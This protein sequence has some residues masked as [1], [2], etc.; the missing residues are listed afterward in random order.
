[1]ADDLKWYFLAALIVLGLGGL[2]LAAVFWP[3]PG[4]PQRLGWVRW[5]GLGLVLLAL[6][7]G[8]AWVNTYVRWMVWPLWDAAPEA[9]VIE[10][11]GATR[12]RVWGDGRIIWGDKESG[13]HEGRLSAAQMLDLLRQGD[14]VDVLP[15]GFQ[16]DGVY[17]QITVHF[18]T[19][20]RK[21]QA[22]TASNW[23]IKNQCSVYAERL[24][25]AA[26]ASA[27]TAP[28]T[29]ATRFVQ[30][31]IVAPTDTCWRT[32]TWDSAAMGYALASIS[33]R[34]R[35]ITP[36]ET[37]A[38]AALMA[39]SILGHCLQEGP[40]RYYLEVFPPLEFP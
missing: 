31:H 18:L 28:Y 8:N 39:S 12:V 33:W 6:Y 38:L 32:T 4:K 29:G 35:W 11:Q 19:G 22:Y 14:L 1:M 30:A 13:M 9:V 2:G 23:F 5:V 36:T 17:E 34:G 16:I 7:Q 27:E 21:C 26:A 3:R 10:G 24:V 37:Q 40:A 20:P 15:L 25:A